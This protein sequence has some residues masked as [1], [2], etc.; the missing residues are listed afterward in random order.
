MPFA[1][2]Q[3]QTSA[4]PLRMRLAEPAAS[5]LAEPPLMGAE[6]HAIPP[7]VPPV[8]V[9][10]VPP[11]SPAVP[12]DVPPVPVGVPPGSQPGSV[13]AMRPAP[14]P[15]QKSRRETPPRKHGGNLSSGTISSSSGG[16]SQDI[17]A[18]ASRTGS[19]AQLRLERAS[20]SSR[21]APDA[22]KCVHPLAGASLQR[23]AS[24]MGG[25]TRQE[26]PV[27]R[28][29]TAVNLPAR[30]RRVVSGAG[31]VQVDRTIPCP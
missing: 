10:D 16:F 30:T 4:P 1:S 11:V 13:S 12:P 14:R 17:A 20:C 28:D 8:V 5:A 23:H 25:P 27:R 26:A 9:P 24:G 19:E 22:K 6:G 31:L 15:A 7:V 3:I 18:D 2:L 21:R 29:R